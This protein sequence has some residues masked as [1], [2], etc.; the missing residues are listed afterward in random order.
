MEARDIQPLRWPMVST[1]DWCSSESINSHPLASSSLPP[2]TRPILLAFER[3]LSAI[4]KFSNPTILLIGRLLLPMAVRATSRGLREL[5]FK[6]Y[7]EEALDKCKCYLIIIEEHGR[8][9]KLPNLWSSSHAKG[10]RKRNLKETKKS[11]MLGRTRLALN[12]Y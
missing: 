7:A 3:D 5:S 4:L 11:R 9:L 12:R 10:I 2:N 6:I 1:G 8:C